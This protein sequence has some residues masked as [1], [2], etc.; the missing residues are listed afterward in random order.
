[1]TIELKK[2]GVSPPE[3]I[4]VTD[5]RRLPK[6]DGI[7]DM[8]GRCPNSAA[9]NHND[10]NFSCFISSSERRV[11]CRF[12]CKFAANFWDDKYSD[13]LIKTK[14]I[15]EEAYDYPDKNRE[16]RFQILRYEAPPPKNK[17]FL[18][19]RPN[20][21]KPGKWIWNMK[22]IERVIYNLPEVIARKDE[23]LCFV[24]GEKAANFLM[25]I[26]ILAT[27]V[28]GGSA[29]WKDYYSPAF[30]DR[31]VILIPDKDDPGKRLCQEAGNGI[32]QYAKEVRWLDLPGLEEGQGADDWFNKK[33][34]SDGLTIEQA[35]EEFL[36]L[37][38]K[39]S[40]Y[41]PIEDNFIKEEFFN[42]KV[43]G[44]IFLK[45]NEFKR[46]R[47]D[48]F[49]AYI[50][51]EKI[52]FEDKGDTAKLLSA[53]YLLLKDQATHRVEEVVKYIKRVSLLGIGVWKKIN[54]PPELIPFNN[55]IVDAT[56]VNNTKI[57]EYSKKHFFRSK[58]AVNYNPEHTECPT[59][60]RII[61]EILPEKR[62]IDVY[63][64]FAYCLWRDY[65]KHKFFIWWG[66]GRNGKGEIARALTT[67]ILG[68]NNISGWPA[69]KLADRFSVAGL[70]EKYANVGGEESQLP[71]ASA[72]ILKELTGN[73]LITAEKKGKDQFEF[74]N[75]AKIFLIGNYIPH[76]ADM[77]DGYCSRPHI[78]YF[79][80]RFL[81]KKFVKKNEE[82]VM[83][84]VDKIMR[85]VLK[86]EWEGLAYR[87]VNVYLKQL[88]KNN[89]TFTNEISIEA[90]RAYYEAQTE[91]VLNFIFTKCD[92]L[93]ESWVWCNEFKKE[94]VKW[95]KEEGLAP[96]TERQVADKMG[97]RGL[98]W[99]RK[100]IADMTKRK[101][102]GKLGLKRSAYM[103]LAWKNDEKE[104]DMSST[105]Q[106]V[107]SRI[108]GKIQ[109]SFDLEEE[110]KEVFSSTGKQIITEIDGEYLKPEEMP[111]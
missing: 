77:S 81:P 34:L 51:P 33:I 80:K 104:M 29:G 107:I 27:T 2:P 84:E 58:L 95:C 92:E 49:W 110:S 75:F 111:E 25:K 18:A 1:M 19:R 90:T 78:T 89:W 52:W 53:E 67:Y 74:P 57:I 54:P 4:I 73:Q 103:G 109:G 40:E 13:K 32:E 102:D 65:P 69:S 15:F 101:P 6:P 21:D 82:G 63:E 59:F 47:W 46:D 96:I 87:L 48:R 72:A 31:S 97:T 64:A 100:E 98:Y 76:T 94:V 66:Q 68:E 16:L 71:L 38:K 7:W 14:K 8:I 105:G 36:D 26:G 37:I 62:R 56:D 44:D 20:P 106:R 50:P 41:I 12:V 23:E 39:T 86:E 42:C 70:F 35:K 5:Y 88:R 85:T 45:K 22:G 60:D 61:S 43:Y 30:T 93:V 108:E 83:V 10:N 79:P 99:P 17:T 3:K 28:S 24:E 11:L 55:C 91:P 9:H